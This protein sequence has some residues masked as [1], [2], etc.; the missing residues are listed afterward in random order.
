VEAKPITKCDGATAT[1]FLKE[2]IFRYG[3][4]H[5]IITDNGSNFF[6]GDMAK[7]CREKGIRLD[8]SSVAHP[9]SNGQAE[10]ANQMVLHG[11]KPRLQVP[12][13][14]TPGCWIEEPPFV[15]WGIQTTPNRPTGFTPFFM[16]YGAEAVKPSDLEHDSPR[17]A[18]Y[19]E[20]DN[21]S[22]RQDGLDHL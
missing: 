12:L 9:Q 19:I 2:I 8:I 11:I 20:K 22:T 6:V 21:E 10:R 13:E 7:F 5:S 15:L 17:V 4:P 1:K 16:V 18:A 14:C 3:Y